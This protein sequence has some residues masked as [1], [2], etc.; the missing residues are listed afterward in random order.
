MIKNEAQIQSVALFFYLILLDAEE[1][2]ALASAV[3]KKI[4]KESQNSNQLDPSYLIFLMQD[5]ISKVSKR[6]RKS[7][8]LAVNQGSWVLPVDCD[9]GIWQAFV[10]KSDAE[11]LQCLIWSQVLGFSDH[12]IAKGLGVSEGT[13]R[14]RGGRALLKL[15]NQMIKAS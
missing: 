11:E 4:N 9:F 8:N 5:Q 3:V 10:R 7:Q 2:L 1:S 13:V 6:S 14:Y 15:G 12:D